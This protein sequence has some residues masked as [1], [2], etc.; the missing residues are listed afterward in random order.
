[1]EIQDALHRNAPIRPGALNGCAVAIDWDTRRVG[2]SR[3]ALDRVI[4]QAGGR[5]ARGTDLA[6]IRVS[7]RTH[8]KGAADNEAYGA[9]TT[10]TLRPTDFVD[11][12]YG[13]QNLR[14]A[15]ETSYRRDGF[16][17]LLPPEPFVWQTAL[18]RAADAFTDPF[19]VAF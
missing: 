8:R 1:M 6:T 5:I 15:I 3:A 14:D 9:T 18:N 16:E 17:P 7:F 4:K 2:L 10:P 13:R 11:V 12:L 19:A